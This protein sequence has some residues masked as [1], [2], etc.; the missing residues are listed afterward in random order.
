MTFS[1]SR[2]Q[3]SR[4]G[5]GCP[6]TVLRPLRRRTADEDILFR[7][8]FLKDGFGRRTDE[9]GP[10]RTEKDDGRRR[11]VHSSDRF[12]TADR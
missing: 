3:A 8:T 5:D 4:D 12:R 1:R 10:K 6:G 11:T 9:F 7:T 2:D